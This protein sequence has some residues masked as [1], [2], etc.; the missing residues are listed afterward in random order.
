MQFTVCFKYN[1]NIF[2]DTQ[3]TLAAVLSNSE[4]HIL[5]YENEQLSDCAILK[6]DKGLI[7]GVKFSGDNK[8]NLFTASSNGVVKLW[9]LR[10]SPEKS[11]LEFIG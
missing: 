10:C 11:V 5:K 9:D 3:P 4:V 8:Q 1:H 2:S 6:E 7:V